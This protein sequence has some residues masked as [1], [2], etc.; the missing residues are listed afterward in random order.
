MAKKCKYASG[1]DS[2]NCAC[3]CSS[4]NNGH[5]GKR[6]AVAFIKGKSGPPANVKRCINGKYLGITPSQCKYYK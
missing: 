6:V 1:N 2:N 3:F 4:P 5:N